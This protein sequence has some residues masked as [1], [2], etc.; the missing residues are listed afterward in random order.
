MGVLG[1]KIKQEFPSCIS[2]DVPVLYDEGILDIKSISA[3]NRFVKNHFYQGRKTVYRITTSLGYSLKCTL[4]H[5]IKTPNGF[6]EAENLKVADTV[7][8]SHGDFCDT[9]QRVELSTFPIANHYVFIDEEI[10]SFLG[11]FIGDGSFYEDALSIAC[12]SQDQD[13]V[14]HVIALIKSLFGLIRAL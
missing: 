1:D 7:C 3:N 6:V 8:L 14:Q 2:A 4:D 9:S 11:Y 13:V 10:A 5:Q 12:D